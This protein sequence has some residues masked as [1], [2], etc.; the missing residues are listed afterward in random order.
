MTLTLANKTIKVIP[1]IG[2]VAA[3]V[4]SKP[5]KINYSCSSVRHNLLA[6]FRS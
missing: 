3:G 4:D 6:I 5:T 1:T 2:V